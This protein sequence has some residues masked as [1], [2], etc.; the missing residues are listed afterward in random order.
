MVKKICMLTAVV[1]KFTPK[2]D[3][4]EPKEIKFLKLKKCV[5]LKN[6]PAPARRRRSPQLTA[7]EEAA[8]DEGHDIAR[9]RRAELT[10]EEEAA[11][12]EGHD[13]ARSRR[14]ELTAEEEA[15]ADEVLLRS[16]LVKKGRMIDL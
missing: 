11:A 1:E 13:I 8:A 2:T 4:E 15:I 6:Q 10:A 16:L 3:D 14:A 7:E 12:D 5:P 9:S